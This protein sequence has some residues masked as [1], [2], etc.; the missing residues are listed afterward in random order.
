MKR[1]SFLRTGAVLGVGSVGALPG[2]AAAVRTERKRQSEVLRLSS[3][4]N[5]LGLAP[6]AREA[7]IEGIE[8][9]NRYPGEAR[10]RMV[11]ALARRHDVPEECVVLGNGST[12]VLQMSVQALG[13]AGGRLILAEPTYEDVPW[14]A[15]PIDYHLVRVP[16][17]ADASHDLARMR[18]A[19]D[20]A[21]ARVLV[22][23]CNPNNPTGTLTSSAALDRWIEAA[24]PERVCF[25]V[26]EAYFDYV[27]EASYWSCVPWVVRRPNVIVVRTFSKIFGMAGLRLGYGIAHPETAELLKRYIGRNNANQLAL[28]AGLASL[29]DEGMVE[30]SLSANQRAREILVAC[31]DELGLEHLPS[32]TNFVMHRIAGDLDTYRRRMRERG[33]W[34]GRPFPPMLSHN[35]LSLGTPEEMERFADTLREFRSRGWV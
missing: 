7:V 35:R 32:H 28:V 11:E 14:Y 24:P 26:D 2:L 19:A 4:E 34:V 31:L 5:P 1:R 25:L 17:R 10:R 18:E 16:L 29:R 12:E 15:R 30:R 20:D 6:S 23:V 21:A 13:E 22:Y 8:A 27:R 9:A 33:V 3:N